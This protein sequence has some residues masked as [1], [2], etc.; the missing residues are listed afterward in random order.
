MELVGFALGSL[1][2]TQSEVVVCCPVVGD[3][4]HEA[5][6]KNIRE[7]EREDPSKVQVQR[8]AESRIPCPPGPETN[9]CHTTGWCMGTVA[10]Q[11]AIAVANKGVYTKV[12]I[13]GEEG[14][15]ATEKKLLVN[16]H[17]NGTPLT[18]GTQPSAHSTL[19]LLMYW[20]SQQ[21]TV[22]VSGGC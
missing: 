9:Q 1:R 13:Q 21:E 22:Y 2:L 3:A 5:H 14:M 10:G 11:R 17:T 8:H 18:L 15:Q 6:T 12:S 7:R 4:E 16:T 20:W 19:A